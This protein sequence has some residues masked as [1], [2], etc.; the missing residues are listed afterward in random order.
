MRVIAGKAK[1]LKLKT[2]KGDEVRPT[3]DRIKETLFNILQPKLY[4]CT[5]LDLFSGSGA[6]GIEALSRGAKSVIFVEKEKEALSC[7][8][9]NLKTTKLEADARVIFLE[10]TKALALLKRENLKFDLIFLDPPYDCLLEQKILECLSDGSLL[11]PHTEI[12][13]EASISTDFSYA[14]EFGFSL[15]QTKH[16]KTNQH[17]FFS[18]KEVKNRG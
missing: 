9:E 8:R 18:S 3:T 10:V 12:I 1:R 6:I 14:E 2:V 17:V 15:L 5:F 16:Y 13:V 7:I 4:G 11:H